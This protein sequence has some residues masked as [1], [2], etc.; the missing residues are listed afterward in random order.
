MKNICL[1][2]EEKVGP[3]FSVQG[4]VEARNK[5]RLAIEKIASQIK[6]GMIE[7]DAVEMAKD[8]LAN[9]GLE[10]TWHPT[11]VRFG[12]NTVKSMLEDSQKG[13]QL[14]EEDIFFIDIAPRHE[15]WEGDG[16]KSFQIGENARYTQC[17][18]DA[19][20]LFHDVRKVW[21][22]QKLSGQQL[23]EY[24]D[25]QALKMGWIL[26]HDLPGHRISDFPHA[27]IHNGSLED[28]SKVPSPM[29]WILEIHLLDKSRKFGAFFED[30]LL[31]DSYYS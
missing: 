11:R 15:F 1:A 28:Y 8:I 6:P 25:A 17:A 19:E 18:R 20:V 23:Y 13:I 21:E 12:C 30:M 9:M 3:S 27:A 29:R 22:R 5:T 10:L 24:A 26:N 16:G 31:N 4:M 2:S 7:E 14:K